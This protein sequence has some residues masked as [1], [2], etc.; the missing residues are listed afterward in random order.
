MLST[1]TKLEFLYQCLSN[2]L[3][4]E[5][6]DGN[7]ANQQLIVD[8]INLN[9]VRIGRQLRITS[10]L[11]VFMK[12]TIESLKE[13]LSL[14]W[15]GNNK[16]I[17]SL[18]NDNALILWNLLDIDHIEETEFLGLIESFIDTAEHL[19]SQLQATM[20]NIQP[21]TVAVGN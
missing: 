6:T 5:L 9:F 15:V 12:D 19:K 4:I 18:E 1:N 8:G 20:L 21:S 17:I 2:E 13:I 14:S 7:A 10:N 16:D 11:G 3:G